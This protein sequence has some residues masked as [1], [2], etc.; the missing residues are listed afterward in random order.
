[1]QSHNV[2]LLKGHQLFRILSFTFLCI[3]THTMECRECFNMCEVCTPFSKLLRHALLGYFS[4][5][6]ETQRTSLLQW[7]LHYIIASG[8][9]IQWRTLA[10][11]V[12]PTLT[13]IIFLWQLANS[14]FFLNIVLTDNF[15]HSVRSCDLL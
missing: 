11:Y 8:L 5:C 12:L 14:C 3:I 7:S 6:C 1:M 10:L 13:P 2:H 15:E 9:F 4:V